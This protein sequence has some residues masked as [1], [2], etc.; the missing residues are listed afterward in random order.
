M[1]A[2]VETAPSC[3]AADRIKQALQEMDVQ[4]GSRKLDYGKVRSILTGEDRHDR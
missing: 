1:I 4:W 3:E 2:D